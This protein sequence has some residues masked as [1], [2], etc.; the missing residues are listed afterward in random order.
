MR[1]KKR[2]EK[3][4]SIESN[5][6]Y[7]C[8]VMII[9]VAVVIWGG[10]FSTLSIFQDPNFDYVYAEYPRDQ[11][12]WPIYA[13]NTPDG[14]GLGDVTGALTLPH[15]PG[16]SPEANIE[17]QKV[18]AGHLRYADGQEV[19]AAT[20][21]GTG[22][23]PSIRVDF[24]M[25]KILRGRVW[26]E[27]IIIITN[28]KSIV[29]SG[30][31]QHDSISSIYLLCAGAAKEISA[32]ENMSK[33]DYLACTEPTTGIFKLLVTLNDEDRKLNRQTYVSVD[34]VELKMPKENTTPTPTPTPVPTPTPT[35]VPTPTPTPVPTPTPTPVPTPT[36]PTS[37]ASP[38]QGL[39]LCA[40][41]LAII[42][43]T[44]FKKPNNKGG[45]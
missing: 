38:V 32:N 12:A 3:F 19:A 25:S 4:F 41:G 24:N 34:H 13:C 35:P 27:Y 40:I 8:G 42:G 16:M 6:R 43:F 36:P 45:K 33:E 14:V 2:I 9:A 23:K 15:M 11:V 22:Q 37:S 10:S 30:L 18:Y 17:L 20:S 21:S 44:Y 7:A 1:L 28:S 39:V 29:D 5:K 31:E 26:P